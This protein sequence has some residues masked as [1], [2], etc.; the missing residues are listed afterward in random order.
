MEREAI[1]AAN[2]LRSPLL[3]LP[4]EI[5]NRIYG[6][7]FYGKNTTRTAL[8]TTCKQVGHEAAPVYYSHIDLSFFD[9]T[10]LKNLGLMRQMNQMIARAKPELLA[11]VKSV[12]TRRGPTEH[13]A[14]CALRAVPRDGYTEYFIFASYLPGLKYWDVCGNMNPVWQ[15]E[16]MKG[17]KK[18]MGRDLDV[19]FDLTK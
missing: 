11:R 9:F 19:T 13:M 3:R 12:C 1:T 5:R 6:F 8:L 17:I 7:V 10:D 18:L 14:R 4:G 15:E 16:V 2:Q